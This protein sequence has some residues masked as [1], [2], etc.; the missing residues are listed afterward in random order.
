[1]II[2]QVGGGKKPTG[3]INI[4]TNGTHDVT[5]YASADVNVPTTAPAHYIKKDIDANGKLITDPLIIN[6]TGVT[7]VSSYCLYSAYRGTAVTG[8][9]DLSGLTTLTGQNALGYCFQNCTGIT[10]IDLSNLTSVS[11]QSSLSSCFNGCTGITSINLSKLN[12]VTGS[13]NFESCFKGCTGVTRMSFSALT[14]IYSA[15]FGECFSNSGLEYLD[16]PVLETLGGQNSNYN[17]PFYHIFNGTTNL[18]KT[19]KFQSLKTVTSNYNNAYCFYQAF[20][21]STS[22]THIY[23]YALDTDSFGTKTNQFNQMLNSSTGA[24]VH[25]P[26]RIQA[27]IGSWSDVTAGFGGTSTTVLF[28]IVTTLTGADSNTYSRQ[29]KDSTAT[30]TAW[31]NNS[32]LYYTSG[33]TEP[34]VGD[35]IYSDSACTTA[36][37]TISSIA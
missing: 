10:S 31:V 3:T 34:Q 29:E 22:N 1:M 7:D 23:F 13:S 4:T 16:F 8:A 35:T 30:A 37:T 25:F 21:K 12:S 2:N 36:V 24:T 11:G 26:K 14:N 9:I 27:T 17:S 5:N 15:Q 32:T 28:D 18:L 6:M 33:T 19:V 20:C